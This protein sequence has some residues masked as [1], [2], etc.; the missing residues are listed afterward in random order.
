VEKIGGQKKVEEVTLNDLASGKKIKVQID[1]V[2]VYIGSKPNTD[3]VKDVVKLDKYGFI[4][5]DKNMKTSATG[6]F[7]AGDV[8]ATP[9][10][11]I[12]TAASDGA[13]AAESARKYIEGPI[14]K[15]ITG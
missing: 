6:I 7:A 15:K 1:G 3:L 2:F 5:T 12:V 13:I 14:Q 8:R 10:R 9:L 4:I 11:Q